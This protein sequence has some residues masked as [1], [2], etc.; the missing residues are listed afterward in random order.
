MAGKVKIGFD[1]QIVTLPLDGILPTKMYTDDIKKSRKYAQILASIK[2]VGIIEPPAV[3]KT[4][5]AGEYILLDGHLRIIALKEIGETEVKCLISKDDEGYTYNKYISRL[6]PIQEYNM[7]E[8][9]LSKGV[10]EQRL[11]EALNVDIRRIHEKKT[12]VHGIC[13]EVVEM[14]KDKIIS[15][16]V[17]RVFKKMRPMRQIEAATLMNDRGSYS[18]AYARA[19]LEGSRP[20]QLTDEARRLKKRSPASI[21]KQL[22]IEEEVMNVNR[23]IKSI[24]ESYGMDMLRLV[25]VQAYLKRLLGNGKVSEYLKDYHPATYEKFTEIAGID[26]LKM[27]S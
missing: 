19:L 13:P 21:E 4:E 1:P 20:E 25:N 18:H 8:K 12:L 14:L 10:S 23:D 7:I 6:S 22:R 3:A 2:H 16:K 27:K 11:A 15:Q 26:T 24:K 9:A 5:N 17:F